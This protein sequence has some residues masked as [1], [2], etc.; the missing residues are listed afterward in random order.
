M[1]YADI[2]PAP[3]G[4]GTGSTTAGGGTALDPN[5]VFL[6]VGNGPPI[7]GDPYRA[8]PCGKWRVAI[9]IPPAL[10]QPGVLSLD[11]RRLTSSM[12]VRGPDQGGDICYGG[13]GSF[14]D[15]TLEIV[16]AGASVNIRL[17]NTATID[18]N[19]NGSYQVARCP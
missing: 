4:S 9:G 12:S 17:A 7:C 8:E 15:G 16:D 5:T 13:G 11:D 18:F 10:F 3:S 2:P 19:A 6:F 14:Y 1:R